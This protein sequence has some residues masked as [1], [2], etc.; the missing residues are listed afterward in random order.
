METETKNS[1]IKANI[2]MLVTEKEQELLT[3][4]REKGFGIFETLSFENGQPVG[5]KKLLENIR[6]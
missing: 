3:L 5:A 1:I 4:I 6:F 2:P